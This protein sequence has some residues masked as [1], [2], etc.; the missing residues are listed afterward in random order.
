MIEL[1]QLFGFAQPT[2]ANEAGKKKPHVDL[3]VADDEPANKIPKV[4]DATMQ[5]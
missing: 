5:F 1:L 3:S 4:T 2:P